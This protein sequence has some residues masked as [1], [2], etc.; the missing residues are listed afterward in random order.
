MA[1]GL[2]DGLPCDGAQKYGFI[3]MD[4]FH[5]PSALSFDGNNSENWRRFRQQ[6]EIYLTALASENKDDTVMIAILLN[7]AGEEAIEV[8]NTF[9]F[10]KRD[11]KKL[12]NVLE[13]FERYC[14]PRKNVVFE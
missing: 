6:Y 7:F 11:E 1:L 5:K 14:G 10:P 12:E 9:Q 4:S 3:K 13:Q 8:F 2:L